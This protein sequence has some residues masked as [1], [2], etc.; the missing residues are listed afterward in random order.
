M[1]DTQTLIENRPPSVAAL[2]LERVAATPDAEAYRYPVPSPS[3]EG[4]DDWKT[5]S[6][7]QAAERVHAIAAGLIQLG[8]RP[9][10][11][12]ALAS[13]TRI[14]WI[15]ADLGIMCA[16]AA[17]TTVYPQTNAEESAFILADSESR[18]LIAEDAA[19]LAKAREKRAELPELAHVV[20]VDAAGVERTAEEG[21]WLLTLDELES[22]GAAHLQKHPELI[23]E[24][25][26]AITKD[27]LATLIY[28]SGTTGRP[29]G[30]RLPHDNWSYMAK[31]TAATG[32][33]HGDDVQYLWLPLAH[34]FGK[35]LTSGQIEVGHVTAVDGR[36]DKIIENLPVVQPTY[37]AAV[38]RIFE[39]VYNGVAAKA[40]AGGAAK[41]KIFQWAAGIAREYAKV[42]QDN[43]RRTGTASAP[44]G[45]TTKHKA[46]DRLVFAKIREAFG[47]RLRACVSGSAALAPD[48][49]YFF[50]GAGIHI[51]EGYGLTE[52]SAASFVN[53]G[54]AYRTGTVG[55]PLP[56][57]EVRI[58]DDGEVLLRG[59]GIMQGYHG[60]PEKTAEVL[61]P[62]G[63]FHTG[64]IGELSPDGYLRITDRK[65][66]LIKTSGG[67][68]VAPAEVEGQFKAVCPYVSN[69]LVHGADRNFC[70]AL[71]ALDE[72]AILGWAKENGLEGKSYAEVVAA[73]ATVALIEL[74]VTEL[75][76]GLQRWQT[77]KKFRLLPRDLDVEHGEMTPSLKLKRP[78]VEREFGHLID[79][80]YAGT[81]EA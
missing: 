50:A 9:E 78:V 52:S 77:I 4:P 36:V 25:V 43:F 8:V 69:I 7:G 49:G 46:A 66:D 27:Q 17:T 51:L 68:Y 18:V 35:V 54:E 31:A 21:D 32:L 75:N 19:Q 26:G 67:K 62:D 14:E 72:E 20:V 23:K 13:S 24:R 64:D 61:E 60:L 80:M 28:T 73:P 81:R 44:F 6:W 71:I 40:R 11:R 37:M 5:L 63:W 1:S 30:V 48:I 42:T 79:E 10:E 15:L 58:A 16:G 33:I 39:K 12:V 29:K 22:R 41:Y 76:Q 65:K 2:F 45:L 70:T 47:G 56:G 55:K 3:G 38:P 74:Y 34:V 59:P 53:P 57:T